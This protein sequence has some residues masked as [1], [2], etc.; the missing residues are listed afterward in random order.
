MN[1][2]ILERYFHGRASE[3]EKRQIGAWLLSG[4]EA[5]QEFKQVKFISEGITLYGRREKKLSGKT[6]FALKT[7]RVIRW[8]AV[9]ASFVL[10][11]LGAMYL[12]RN[13]TIEELSSEM[14]AFETAPGQRVDITLADGSVVSLN[15]CSRIEYPSTFR[16]KERHITLNGE[17]LF[18]VKHDQER[19]FIVSTFATNLEVRGTT[20]SVNADEEE[21]YFCTA[22]LEGSVIVTNLADP[23]DVHLMHP[24]DVLTLTNGKLHRSVISEFNPLSWV[25]G[26]VDL[27]ATDFTALMRKFEKAYGVQIVTRANPPIKGLSGELRISEGI[28]H[29]L[30]VLQHVVDFHYEVYENIIIIKE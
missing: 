4:P 24:S 5:M 1:Q 27:E 12:V 22:L 2:D 23:T 20:F 18:R 29:A 13:K 14:I 21:Q 17:A 11:M 8:F 25:D 28:E 15:S 30:K 7:H 10:F 19:P 26:V 16:G 3:E 6:N 9:A